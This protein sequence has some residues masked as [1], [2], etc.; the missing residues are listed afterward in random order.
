MA[1]LTASVYAFEP[2]RLS[3]RISRSGP[4]FSQAG[5]AAADERDLVEHGADRVLRAAVQVRQPRLVEAAR[6]GADARADGHLV[7][8]EDD[9]QVLVQPAGVVHGLEDDAGGEGAVAD[10]GD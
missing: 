1:E 4:T 10:D 9:E 8:V 3:D 6:Q 2:P 5:G 7:V